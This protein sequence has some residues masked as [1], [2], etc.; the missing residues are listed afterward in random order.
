MTA[1]S[2]VFDYPIKRPYPWRFTTI[3][4]FAAS[5][6]VLAGLL[7]FNL[8]IVGLASTS[9]T[10]STF[11]KSQD[12]SW[13]DRLNLNKALNRTTSC[14]PT[15]LVSGGAYRTQNGV[16][17]Y[18][19][20]SITSTEDGQ[21]LSMLAYEGSVIENCTIAG[22]AG[23]G[24]FGRAEVKVKAKINCTLPGNIELITA[25]DTVIFSVAPLDFVSK[26]QNR[27][28]RNETNIAQTT[29]QLVEMFTADV[30]TNF[31]SLLEAYN[32]SFSTCYVWDSW[33]SIG[34]FG[35]GQTCN[36]D[37]PTE[38]EV[39][40]VV[41]TLNNLAQI[42]W[43]AVLL[44]L[45]VT[46]PY[47]RLSDLDLMR[48]SLEP[49]LVVLAGLNISWPHVNLAAD[50]VLANMTGLG[51]PLKQPQPVPFNAR[52]LCHKMWWKTPTNL[53]LDMLVA[54]VSLFMAYWAVLN[55]A[56]RYFAT[57]SSLH[58]NHCVC[59]S[60]NELPP[61]ESIAS[62]AH[63]L[64]SMSDEVAYNGFSGIDYLVIHIMRVYE[65]LDWWITKA[66]RH[67]RTHIARASSWGYRHQFL[68]ALF[69]L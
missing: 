31:G 29:S 40:S 9:F 67:K 4:I 59:P 37:F 18:T 68:Y 17:A 30:Y 32:Y 61:H 13:I 5:T 50:R 54:T 35:Y 14:D 16:F 6:I 34:D 33:D 41:F 39:R 7:Y 12:P 20:E 26:S 2:V 62:E 22:M 60:C 48:R 57:R 25:L 19:L 66:I 52:Y 45:G 51:L 36:D 38:G 15:T 21:A 65:A 49:N 46:A 58:G 27:K 44:D 43:S 11:V 28:Q 64:R 55:L 23:M 1:P 47:N 8:A 56:L 24:D 10:S 42:L 53:A 69:D 3:S 63:E